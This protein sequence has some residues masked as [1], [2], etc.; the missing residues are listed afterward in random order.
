MFKLMRKVRKGERG[1]VAIEFAIIFPVMILIVMGIIEFASFFN[2]QLAIT[3]ASRE[4]ARLAS[5]G[6]WDEAEI[7]QRA[8][9]VQNITITTTPSNLASATRGDRI[10]IEISHFYRWTFLPLPGEGTTLVS[11]STMRKE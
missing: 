11:S 2:A 9:P 3:H 5:I 1:A 7:R 6:L 4:G 10:T 8:F